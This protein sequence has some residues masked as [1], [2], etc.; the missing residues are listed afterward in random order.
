MIQESY[1]VT[2]DIISYL[3]SES[4]PKIDVASDPV[5]VSVVLCY[6]FCDLCLSPNDFNLRS[7]LAEQ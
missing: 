3:L 5:R 1:D 2:K 4:L 7:F 6:C